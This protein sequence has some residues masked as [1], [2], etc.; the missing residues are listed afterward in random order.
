MVID[1]FMLY[2]FVRRLATPFEEWEAY[3]EG[4]IDEKGNIILPKSQ[5]RTLAQK[6]AFTKFDLL[7]LNLKKLLGKLPGGQTKLASYAA[8]LWLIK[9]EKYQT[10]SFLSENEED[11]I[12]EEEFKDY[13][14]YE[15]LTGSDAYKFSW[16]KMSDDVMEATFDAKPGQIVV[17]FTKEDDNWEINF[18][19][20]NG[21]T[22][23]TDEGD[24]FAILNTVLAIISNFVKIKKP[25]RMSFK[26]ETR[27]K[28]RNKSSQARSKIYKR[29][30]KKHASQ[31][32]YNFG[33]QSDNI[34]T[35][36]VL[37]R[38]NLKEEIATNNVSSGNI[39]GLGHGPDGE[40]GVSKKKQKKWTSKNKKKKIKTF[41]EKE[42]L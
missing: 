4:I 17:K 19:D 42:N 36:F 21:N 10:G 29:L 3:E 18:F 20:K 30:V 22:S 27:I 39:A 38:K 5:R 41:K 23:A 16:R 13:V 32:G 8:A 11:M 9:E 34:E 37:T 25:K 24:Q 14:L 40:P 28:S 7:V 12:N 15:V 26:S 2:Q 35:D 33:F 6:K 1:I 31:I